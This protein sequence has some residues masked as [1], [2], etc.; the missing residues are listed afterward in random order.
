MFPTAFLSPFP[1][2]GR[3]PK[4]S[5]KTTTAPRMVA[6]T[7]QKNM[8][9]RQLLSEDKIHLMPCCFDGLSAKLVQ[10]A[11]FDFT[12]MSGFAT[13]GARGMPDTGLLSFKEVEQAVSHIS[14]VIDIPVIADGD[15][16]FGNPVNVFRTVT[17]FARAGASGVLIEDQ[18]N[19]KR[20][21]QPPLLCSLRSADSSASLH[22]ISHSFCTPEL[23][24][25]VGSHLT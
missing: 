5:M 6:S 15:T 4:R 14:S 24:N 1:I 17:Q 13:A 2:A 12:F 9:L 25:V 22:F 3:A 16:G 10:R 8:K 19:P 11:G 20:Y 18:V 21:V 23:G 7:R